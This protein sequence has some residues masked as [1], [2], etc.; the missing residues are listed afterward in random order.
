MNSSVTNKLIAPGRMDVVE[1]VL[2]TDPFFRAKIRKDSA[3]RQFTNRRGIA[4]RY[5]DLTIKLVTRLAEIGLDAVQM[6]RDEILA[7][8]FEFCELGEE[9]AAA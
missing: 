5:N 3:R 2:T 9:M 4:K 6:R 8:A 7:K 1:Q